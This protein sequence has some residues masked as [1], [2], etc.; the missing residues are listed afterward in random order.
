MTKLIKSIQIANEKLLFNTQQYKGK[1]CLKKKH[2]GNH[3]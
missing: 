3:K 2:A 1:S